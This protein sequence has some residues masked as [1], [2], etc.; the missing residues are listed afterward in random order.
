[1]KIGHVRGERTGRGG[2]AAVRSWRAIR[3]RVAQACVLAGLLACDSATEPDPNT[4]A[5]LLV[6]AGDFQIARAGEAVDVPP[7]FG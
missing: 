5:A 2:R 6:H 4:P 1:M 3:S 7:K